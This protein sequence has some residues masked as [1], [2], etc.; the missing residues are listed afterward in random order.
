MEI[1]DTYGVIHNGNL[2]DHIA[3]RM[4][5]ACLQTLVTYNLKGH[6]TI[7]QVK[8]LSP[9][10]GIT[11]FTKDPFGCIGSVGLGERGMPAETI[12]KQTTEKFI[13]YIQ[14]GGTVDPFLFDQLL[15]FLVLGNNNSTLRVNRL[16]NH[17]K[18]HMWLLEQFLPGIT[19]FEISEYSGGYSL[20]IHGQ[21]LIQK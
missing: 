5:H 6:I 11:L 20:L 19:L 21:N 10:T 12:A 1:S 17:A 15:P 16:S 4:K 9:G 14:S 13:S 2:P 18:T 8:S 7:E 3:K